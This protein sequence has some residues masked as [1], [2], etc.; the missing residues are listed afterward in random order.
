MPNKH[1][2]SDEER[3]KMYSMYEVNEPYVRHSVTILFEMSR[4]DWL[5]LKASKEFERAVDYLWRLKNEAEPTGKIP[6]DKER[7]GMYSAHEFNEY[8]NRRFVIVSFGL[9]HHDW[10]K[11]ERSEGFREMVDYLWELEMKQ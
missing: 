4:R 5:T 6:S 11:F 7:A 2:L 1:R 8:G 9:A 10:L 3:A